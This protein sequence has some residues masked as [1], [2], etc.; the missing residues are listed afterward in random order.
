MMTFPW[1]IV[2]GCLA[3][4]VLVPMVFSWG[5][6]YTKHPMFLIY[7]LSHGLIVGT[8]ESIHITITS[9]M[10]LYKIYTVRRYRFMEFLFD[11]LVRRDGLRYVLLWLLNIFNI[12]AFL[13]TVLVGSND[14]TAQ[15]FHASAY[16][17][18]ICLFMFMKD[19]YETATQ[20]M[21]SR[22]I[23]GIKTS[24]TTNGPPLTT[25]FAKSVIPVS[26]PASSPQSAYENNIS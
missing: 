11:W 9:S 17:K 7:L 18:S 1:V 20:V 8:G 4:S 26:V 6:S 19:S 24:L 21:D 3:V 12:T 5:L 16:A 22:Q 25:G 10:F 2:I 14:V 13:L 23:E 15:L